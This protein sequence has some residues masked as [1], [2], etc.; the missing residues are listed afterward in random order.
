MY[1]VQA[2]V[3]AAVKPPMAKISNVFGRL[4][5]FSIS[6]L[7]YVLG[8]V[9]SAASQ[10]IQTFAA[11]QIFY[12]SGFTGLLISQQIFIADTSDLTWRV[13][14]S[15]L[16][17]VPFLFTVW[18]GPIIAQDLYIN[19]RW[20]Y[21]L[22]AIVLP[23]CFL[24][25]A[26]A[27]L[28]NARKAKRLGLLPARPWAGV[29]LG[30][31]L[32]GLFF[33]L[34]V[35]GLLLLS[36]AISLIL[37]PLTL[38]A[39]DGW[40]NG[41]IV[42]MLVVGCVCLVAFPAWEAVPRLAPRPFLALRMLRRRNVA[43]GCATGFF[44]YAVF[45][46]SVFP[47]YSSYLQVVQGQ[48]VEA[49]GHI[50][51]TFS[52]TSTVAAV[53]A[54]LLIKA[55]RV[56]KPW[57]VLGAAV[58]LLGIGLMIRYRVPG[59]GVG[60]QVGTQIAVGIGG[61]LFSVPMQLAVQAAVPHQ[62]VAAATAIYLTAVEIGGAVGSAVSGAIW[63]ANLPAKLAAYLPAAE[64]SQAA[65]IYASLLVAESYPAGSPAGLAIDRAYQE[66]MDLLL[67]VAVC[68]AAPVMLGSLAIRG[69]RLDR[70]DQ[71]VAGN[72][73]GADRRGS[74]PTDSGDAHVAETDRPGTA[75]LRRWYGVV[76]K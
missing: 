30:P 35:M 11:A 50:T 37:I 31:A 10:N 3:N 70:V 9:M 48:S 15:A 1:V 28:V 65:D 56:Y 26:L 49:A 52:F 25:L 71:R 18:C 59:S 27:L 21:G 47:Y 60:A 46:T 16:P 61:G 38:A 55:T 54:G 73:I 57:I 64:Q 42:A 32:R 41:S 19:W 76:R 34:D 36:A 63:T 33:E 13:L 62:D 45:Y 66:T 53:A 39:T 4:E 7:L 14:F 5:A 74:A 2:V 75:V 51:Q 8:Y 43:L 69:V 12:S 40:A 22:W 20:G 6:I 44:Y 29:A 72:V 23:A 67:I 58:Y 17:D 24:P 68:F